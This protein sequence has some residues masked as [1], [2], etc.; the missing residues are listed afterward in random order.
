MILPH[1]KHRCRN[2]LIITDRS[3]LDY[4]ERWEGYDSFE[5]DTKDSQGFLTTL[6]EVSYLF[7]V[8]FLIN[9]L[10]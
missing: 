7:F 2:G 5:V 1:D 10:T 3:Y 6:K 4:V 8:F 9:L